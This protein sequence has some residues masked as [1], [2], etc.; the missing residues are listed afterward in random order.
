MTNSTVRHPKRGK[1]LLQ[2]VKEHGP[3]NID[4]I[5]K[6][7]EPGGNIFPTNVSHWSV[8]CRQANRKAFWNRAKTKISIHVKDWR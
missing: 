3:L 1:D 5:F 8:I 7:L 2:L 4:L 6:M